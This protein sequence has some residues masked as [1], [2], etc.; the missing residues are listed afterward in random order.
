MTTLQ[1]TINLNNYVIEI[2]FNSLIK[3]RPYLVRIFNYDID[4]VEMRATQ[5]EID[6]FLVDI[7]MSQGED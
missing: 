4:I 6:N 3:D 7:G 5:T 2:H 1:R